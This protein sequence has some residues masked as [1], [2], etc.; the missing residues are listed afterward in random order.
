MI[1]LETTPLVETLPVWVWFCGLLVTSVVGP[2]VVAWINNKKI[3][4]EAATTREDVAEIRN[5]VAN[6]HDSNLRDDLDEK[7]EAMS[8]KF[9][10]VQT[11]LE[12]VRN[13]LGGL[14]SET[15]DLRN[16]VQGLRAD[17]R[18]DRRSIAEIRSEVAEQVKSGI[19]EHTDRCLQKL[20]KR[21]TP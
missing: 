9:G 15:R 4:A 6:T 3:R 16:D 2:S 7:F 14:H 21:E 10:L 18:H 19:Q 11:G 5:Q 13:D 17:A 20:E 12:G 1:T 8:T